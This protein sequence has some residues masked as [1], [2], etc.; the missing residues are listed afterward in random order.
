[1]KMFRKIMFGAAVM[2]L[3]AAGDA[4]AAGNKLVLDG[5][6]TV[7]PIAKGELPE[8]ENDERVERATDDGQHDCGEQCGTTFCK[9][10]FHGLLFHF[11]PC[12]FHNFVLSC[13]S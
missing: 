3:L 7:G 9:E 13:F 11:V 6:T 5:S 4:S 10:L 2:S 12:I 1:M 8:A